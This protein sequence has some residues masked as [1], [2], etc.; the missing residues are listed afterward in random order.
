MK[1]QIETNFNGRKAIV[2][3]KNHAH[4]KSVCVYRG[5]YKTCAGVG[6]RFEDANT[7]EEFYVF[8]YDEVLWISELAPIE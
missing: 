8:N 3:S 7:H 5:I 2:I 4:Y 6:M 1:N